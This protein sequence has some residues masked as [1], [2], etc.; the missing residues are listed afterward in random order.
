MVRIGQRAD[1]IRKFGDVTYP[2]VACRRS[3][4]HV[5]FHPVRVRHRP[6]C[7]W[8]SRWRVADADTRSRARKVHI[9]RVIKRHRQTRNW[10]TVPGYCRR[11]FCR[12]ACCNRREVDGVAASFVRE[13]SSL[14]PPDKKKLRNTLRL[15]D[16]KLNVRSLDYLSWRWHHV[17]CAQTRT[18]TNFQLFFF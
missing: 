2:V 13:L 8:R 12:H 1:R 7:D 9:Q 14:I 11:H 3:E 6:T 17:D 16:R 15:F 18:A 4:T 10:S 5:Y